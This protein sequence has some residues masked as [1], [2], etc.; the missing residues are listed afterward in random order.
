M[1]L[2]AWA[3]LKVAQTGYLDLVR[4]VLLLQVEYEKQLELK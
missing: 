2:D 1:V 4:D 3:N